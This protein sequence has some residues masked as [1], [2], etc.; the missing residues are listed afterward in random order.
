MGVMPDR[1]IEQ[2]ATEQQMIEPF[3]AGQV[4]DGVISYGLSSYGYDFRVADEFRL[5]DASALSSQGLD[6][7]VG[8]PDD[9]FTVIQSE[10]AIVLPPQTFVMAMSLE[11]FRMPRDV[12]GLCTGKST[13]AR[14]GVLV[15]ITPLE[16]EWEGRL[17]FSIAN[18]TNVPVQVYPNEGIA[19]L[20]FLKAEDVCAVS[21]R[22]RK[23][24][25]QAQQGITMPTAG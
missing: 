20:V 21:Y 6:P 3:E 7:K 24:R 1:W 11:Y 17:T 14:M 4:R 16:P 2:M 18:T 15:N 13:Y 25:Y 8:V 5:F 19:Q 22:D 12:L 10:T 9:A 23:G